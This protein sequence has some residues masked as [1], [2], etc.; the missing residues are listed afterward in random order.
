[1]ATKSVGAFDSASPTKTVL[2]VAM[3]DAG[4]ER[5]TVSVPI[6]PA[7]TDIEINAYVDAMQAAINATIF[8]VKKQIIEEATPVEANADTTP[9]V[10]VYDNIVLLYKNVPALATFN[11]FLPSPKGIQVLDGDTVDTDDPL[12]TAWRDALT[13]IAPANFT[14]VTA[15]FTERRDKNDSVPA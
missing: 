4:G 1:M 12:Y 3:M 2:S 8:S 7:S 11:G 9:Y 15:R 13:A 10:S 14:V 5:R 6:D